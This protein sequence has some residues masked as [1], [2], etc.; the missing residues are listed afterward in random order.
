MNLTFSDTVEII[1]AGILVFAATFGLIACVI[2][3]LQASQKK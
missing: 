2:I 1:F 3:L